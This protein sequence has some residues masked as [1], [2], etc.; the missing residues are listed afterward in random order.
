MRC[1]CGEKR[2]MGFEK[3]VF[4]ANGERKEIILYFC[5]GFLK[6]TD[7]DERAITL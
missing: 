6:K 1:L 7:H 3:K 5:G 2:G 4:C